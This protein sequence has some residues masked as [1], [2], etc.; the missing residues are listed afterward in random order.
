M[1]SAGLL[2]RTAAAAAA[3]A[4]VGCTPGPA[5]GPSDAPSRAASTSPSAPPPSSPSPTPSPTPEPSPTVREVPRVAVTSVTDVVTGLDAPWGLALLPDGTALV[6]ERDTGDVLLLTLDD[7]EQRGSVVTVG[8]P[9]ARD[10]RDAVRPDSEGGLLGITVSPGFAGDATVFVY[11]TA[12]K[13]NRVLRMRL[14]PSADGADLTAATVVLDGI[15][16]GPNHNGGRLAFGPD[17]HLYVTTGDVYDTS[18]APDPGSLGGKI[19]RITPDGDPAP[20][21]PDPASPVWSSG[22]RNVQGIGWALD[23]RMFASEFG[24]DTWDELNEIEAGGDYGWPD[25]EGEGGGE[26][27]VDPLVVWS[28]D[29]ASPSGLAVTDEGVYLAGLRGRTLWRVPFDGEG[30][31]APQPLLRGE[32]GRL[33][34]V[35]EAPDGALWVTTSNT[36]GRG[37]PVE[38]DDRV[39]RVVV[40]PAG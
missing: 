24:Q 31:G 7:G 39:L 28:T 29:E 25:V 9:G 14:E 37:R 4:L 33:R 38:G 27:V 35:V 34:T 13:D 18:L 1:R 6:T 3:V 10:I 17:G 16:K 40:E 11:L 30:T 21:N 2:R 22:H 32:H 20:G 23:G 19:L 5:P 12:A 26:G 36:D 8:G 15:P